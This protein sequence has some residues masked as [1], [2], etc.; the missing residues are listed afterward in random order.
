M[1]P[2]HHHVTSSH[3]SFA[4]EDGLVHASSTVAVMG[5]A[6]SAPTKQVVEDDDTSSSLDESILSKYSMS[7]VAQSSHVTVASYA[8]ADVCVTGV[9][10]TELPV[11]TQSLP[12]VSRAEDSYRQA[13][14]TVD[15]IHAL[16]ITADV[17]EYAIRS[18]TATPD[19]ASCPQP[20]GS[21][22]VLEQ[23]LEASTR[24]FS[25]RELDEETFRF[26]A[27][28]DE[29]FEERQSTTTD[30]HKA[31]ASQSEQTASPSVA[32]HKSTSA[33]SHFSATLDEL[34]AQD[35][36]RSASQPRPSRASSV[37]TSPTA[38]SLASSY[39]TVAS[40]ADGE[41]LQQP[42]TAQPPGTT[43]HNIPASPAT[44]DETPAQL[45]WTELETP[46]VTDTIEPLVTRHVA[47]TTDDDDD[48]STPVDRRPTPYVWDSPRDRDSSS[49]VGDVN[50][51]KIDLTRGSSQLDVAYHPETP[52]P[53][54]SSLPPSVALNAADVD[55]AQPASPS[56]GFAE[57][58][59]DQADSGVERKSVEISDRVNALLPPL[60]SFLADD[61]FPE[62]SLPVPRR[63]PSSQMLDENIDENTEDVD[64]FV[65]GPYVPD[66][67]G[68]D[69]KTDKV[70]VLKT[71][72]IAK[73]PDVQTG[74]WPEPVRV[75]ERQEQEIT[76]PETR[77]EFVDESPKKPDKGLN[78]VI[79]LDKQAA[80]ISV[81]AGDTDDQISALEQ[82]WSLRQIINDSLREKKRE[83]DEKTDKTD[84]VA[85]SKATSESRP[86]SAVD[87]LAPKQ[88][89][90]DSASDVVLSLSDMDSNEMTSKVPV[91]KTPGTTKKSKAKTDT[92]KPAKAVE[93]IS[94]A[95]RRH[96]TDRKK[97][98]T[99]FVQEMLAEN[100]RRSL[101]QPR[102]TA[103]E[104]PAEDSLTTA[105]LP[106]AALPIATPTRVNEVVKRQCDGTLLAVLNRHTG[107]DVESDDDAAP[108]TAADAE[109]DD[110]LSTLQATSTKPSES[111]GT[112]ET[113]R[114]ELLP[115]PASADDAGDDNQNLPLPQPTKP[116]SDLAP[117]GNVTWSF[118]ESEPAPLS[119]PDDGQGNPPAKKNVIEATLADMDGEDVV[120]ETSW[121]PQWTKLLS[122]ASHQ[123]RTPSRVPAPV[124]TDSSDVA[125]IKPPSPPPPP[126]RSDQ[127]P[128]NEALDSITVT[129]DS[130][131]DEHVLIPINARASRAVSRK[132]KRSSGEPDVE[133]R[134]EIPIRTTNTF[135][136]A[137]TQTKRPVPDKY[138]TLADDVI[139]TRAF[140][141][142]DKL[143]VN[144]TNSA[145][146][147][148][149]QATED[150]AVKFTSCDVGYDGESVILQFNHSD[151]ANVNRKSTLMPPEEPEVSELRDVINDAEFTTIASR[152]RG[153]EMKKSD[154]RPCALLTHLNKRK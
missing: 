15:E 119:E 42:R 34:D 116:S 72:G 112:T 18:L 76:N 147:S 3:V 126:P 141:K 95:Q 154:S 89:T 28:F 107:C 14:T 152:P 113:A 82:K 47:F 129:L 149:R 31:K 139:S 46:S 21:T 45:T 125:E 55:D 56:V 22:E 144:E 53:S 35:A 69:D 98:R 57:T 136:D 124:D 106:A 11:E 73:E 25:A 87:S 71:A 65:P 145:R 83:G 50:P 130:Y 137:T 75:P 20:K 62:E 59:P 109:L 40:V 85:K 58:S 2:H 118:R 48:E 29:D 94:T 68:G 143:D 81:K 26:T 51:A 140:Q 27:A 90:D 132:P 77:S 115:T 92:P 117:A 19:T 127:F 78:D 153:D 110:I 100:S 6:Y 60:P 52:L 37:A 7:L 138:V 86:K 131:D 79:S 30:K 8:T 16:R 64:I 121:W 49:E 93:K 13:A 84:P 10:V 108:S 36:K 135:D 150:V 96:A 5:S 1:K 67:S 105:N 111:V 103:D 97:R 80:T 39:V 61:G 148:S 66:I 24:A 104:V 146:V 38:S 123:T 114:D 12:S 63:V 9:P 74:A 43:C 41:K 142:E 99:T 151:T 4:D 44:T 70:P 128:Q 54:T 23:E 91:S 17:L 134:E 33:A 101:G 32:F 88:P 120:R 133:M 122:R 102:K